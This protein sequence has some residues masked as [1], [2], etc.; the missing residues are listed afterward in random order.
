MSR[1]ERTAWRRPVSARFVG[2]NLKTGAP[3]SGHLHEAHIGTHFARAYV[4]PVS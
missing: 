4:I 3:G 2:P 1:Q